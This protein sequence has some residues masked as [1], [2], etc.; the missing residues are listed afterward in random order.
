[1][2]IQNSVILS[3]AGTDGVQT[4]STLLDGTNAQAASFNSAG[5]FVGRAMFFKVVVVAPSTG[6]PVGTLKVQGTID[7]SRQAGGGSDLP[8]SGL[9]NW[10]DLSFVDPSTGAIST[11]QAVTSSGG[12]FVFQENACGDRYIRVVWTKTSGSITPLVRVQ[13]KGI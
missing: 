4:S 6:S 12:T 7:V 13:Y 2:K 11:T 10:Y 5:F 9:V 8:D 1:M 3:L